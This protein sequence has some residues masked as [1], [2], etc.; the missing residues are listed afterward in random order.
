MSQ[1]FVR[2]Q[3]FGCVGKEQLTS[4]V[5]R[6]LAKRQSSSAYH[7]NHCHAWHV[8]HAHHKAR[9]ANRRPKFYPNDE[10]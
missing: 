10:E 1:R 7:C 8:G 4:D 5:A 9:I 3:T 6:M 2:D